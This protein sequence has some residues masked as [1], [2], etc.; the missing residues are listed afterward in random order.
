MAAVT[1]V[2]DNTTAGFV[3]PD[4]GVYGGVN[5]ST[6]NL[7]S[8]VDQ[9]NDNV[10]ALR[11]TRWYFISVDNADDWTSN[12]PGVV[13]VAWQGADSDDDAGGVFLATAAGGVIQF[14]MQNSSSEGWL[15]V[16][17]SA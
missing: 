16:L 11:F 13:A 3:D 4:R 6:A 1:P 12:L 10:K 15:W 9:H 17:S 7:L 8:G 5:T 14:Q 2:T